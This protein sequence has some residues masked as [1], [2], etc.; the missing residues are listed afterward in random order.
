MTTAVRASGL[1]K[2]YGSVR[3]VRDMSWSAPSGEITAVL[4]PNGAGK[5]TTMECLEGLTR[6][7]SGTAEVL[8]ADPWTAGPEHRARVGVMLQ[9]SGLPNSAKP[10]RLLRHLA[11]LYADPLP[12]QDLVRELGIGWFDLTK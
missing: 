12:L 7:T 5:T 8:G 1:T 4:G 9:D 2:S 6:P 3:A 10:L 11:A